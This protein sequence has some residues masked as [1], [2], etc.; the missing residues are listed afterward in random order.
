M[1]VPSKRLSSST[2]SSA[3]AKS[4]QKQLAL[5]RLVEI[6]EAA[7]LEQISILQAL[8]LEVS[9]EDAKAKAHTRAKHTYRPDDLLEVNFNAT[10]PILELIAQAEEKWES[11]LRRASKTL[12]E[13]VDEYVRRYNRMPPVNFDVW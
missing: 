9:D 11:K 6:E 8:D 13:A 4:R 12:E 2:K 7:E 5:A 1:T 3:H 10:H